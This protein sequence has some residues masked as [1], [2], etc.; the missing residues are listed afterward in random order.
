M[1]FN[2]KITGYHF[3][4][5]IFPI[6]REGSY[7]ELLKLDVD[8]TVQ[9]EQQ[10]RQQRIIALAELLRLYLNKLAFA[11]RITEIGYEDLVN[12][13]FEGAKNLRAKLESEIAD[14]REELENDEALKRNPEQLQQRLDELP[15]KQNSILVSC[16]VVLLSKNL[17]SKLG[18]YRIIIFVLKKSIVIFLLTERINVI[19][20]V[21]FIIK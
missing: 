12:R 8:T 3:V 18:S 13:I 15:S 10:T 16:D 11:D 1:I 7:N 19:F 6:S 4:L 2:R 20:A 9:V 17:K 21:H 5:I 14:L